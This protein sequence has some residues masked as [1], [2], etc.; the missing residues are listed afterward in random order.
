MILSNLDHT[1]LTTE[2]L[3]PLELTELEIEPE[4]PKFPNNLVIF[5]ILCIGELDVAVA[6]KK[7]IAQKEKFSRLTL[8]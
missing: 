6:D 8:P 2:V 7:N 1:Q 4:K 5:F 3:E